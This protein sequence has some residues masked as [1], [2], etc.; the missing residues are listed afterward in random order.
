MGMAS[1]A[2]G[3]IYVADTSSNVV[4]KI[5]A[6]GAVTIVAGNGAAA[7]GGDGGAATAASLNGPEGVAV[8]AAGNVVVRM[9]RTPVICSRITSER[10]SLIQ[11]CAAGLRLKWTRC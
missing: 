2:A 5:T 6:A 7:Y 1:D 3:N 8:D 11:V 9:A 10:P 4:R